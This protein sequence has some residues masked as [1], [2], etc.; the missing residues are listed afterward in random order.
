MERSV[1][2]EFKERNRERGERDGR[3]REKTRVA[4][5]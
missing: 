4:K 3:K 5:K 1:K 2:G